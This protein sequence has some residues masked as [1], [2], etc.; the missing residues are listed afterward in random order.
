MIASAVRVHFLQLIDKSLV[1]MGYFDEKDPAASTSLV[2]LQI[3]FENGE[4]LKVVD[5]DSPICTLDVD[6]NGISWPGFCC[7]YDAFR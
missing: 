3:D 1:L 5:F 7:Q 4:L 6:N 2:L